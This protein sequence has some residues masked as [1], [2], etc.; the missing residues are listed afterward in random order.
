[1]TILSLFLIILPQHLP[2]LEIMTPPPYRCASS[3]EASPFH[4]YLSTPQPYDTTTISLCFKFRSFPFSPLSFYTPTIWYFYIDIRVSMMLFKAI[5]QISCSLTS[6]HSELTPPPYRCASSSEASPFHHYLS[7]PQPYDTTTISLCFKFRSFPFSP[8]SFYTPTIWYFYIDIR[9]SM[10]LFKAIRQISCS[11]T[12]H[13]SELG[14]YRSVG[15][16]RASIKDVNTL[17]HGRTF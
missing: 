5:R 15:I 11:L 6:H 12:S 1:M 4:H 17:V 16:A 13:H 9:V 3:S 14:F 8:L 2:P 10:M 7:T